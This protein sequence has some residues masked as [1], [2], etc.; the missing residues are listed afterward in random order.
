MSGSDATG[1]D[2]ILALTT[3]DGAEKGTEIA[4][5]LVESGLAAC[6]SMVPG[7]T[8]IYRWKG[9]VQKDAEVLLLVKTTRDRLEELMDWV[10]AH[11]PYDVPELLCFD[12]VA[13][14]PD[15][16]IWLQEATHQGRKTRE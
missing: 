2:A 1:C 16:L 5:A 13:G 9:A 11:H 12:G 3:I 8:S 6:V 4:E 10:R 14:N 15:Y 7:L